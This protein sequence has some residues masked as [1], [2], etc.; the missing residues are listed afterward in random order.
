MNAWY[1]VLFM[2]CCYA[3][4]G[5]VNLQ[6][7][8]TAAHNFFNIILK[9][10][11]VLG[12]VFLLLFL[13]NYFINPRKLA[14]HLGK[15]GLLGWA[16]SALGGVISTGPIY[17]WYPLLNE[18]Q[19]NGMRNAFIATFLYTRAIKPALIPL[20]IYYFGL[21]FTIVLTAVMFFFSFI[22]GFVVEK[23]EVML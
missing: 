22:Q 13:F 8:I 18:L 16:L 6:L 9:I 14:E 11:P 10:V 17:L 7:A 19:K 23:L 2:L 4:L 15:R 3:V 21:K 1:F 5:I 12:L 20:L